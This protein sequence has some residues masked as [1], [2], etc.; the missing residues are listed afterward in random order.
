MSEAGPAQAGTLGVVMLVHN[1]LHRVEQVAR[2]WAA[3]GCPVV[4]HVDRNVKNAKPTS[5]SKRSRTNL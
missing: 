5:S 4:L 3:S 2:H 1:S